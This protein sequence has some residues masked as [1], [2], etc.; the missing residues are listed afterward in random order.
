MP[1]SIE[2]QSSV[3]NGNFQS[4]PGDP[5]ANVD[6]L[7]NPLPG[8][9]LV[10][11]VNAT[12]NVTIVADSG[13]GS[14]NVCRFTSV[15]AALND[16]TYLEQLIPVFGTRDQETFHVPST[17]M[18]AGGTLALGLST[19][20]SGQYLLSDQV[21]TTGTAQE[22]LVAWNTFAHGITVPLVNAGGIPTNAGWLRLRLGVR[23]T[24]ASA[25][26]QT[27]DIAYV[28]VNRAT[29]GLYLVDTTNPAARLPGLLNQSGG[30]ARIAPNGQSAVYFEVFDGAGTAANAYARAL[31]ASKDASLGILGSG[32]LQLP[33]SAQPSAGVPAGTFG[34]IHY[35]GTHFYTITNAG[36]HTQI[37]STALPPNGAA[38]G[39]LS[40]TYPNPGYAASPT[41]T[42]TVTAPLIALTGGQIAFPAAQAAS[43]GVN[44]LDDYEEGT[45]TP[46][47]TFATPGNLSVAYSTQNG[48]YVKVG[49][50][51][52]VH[53]DIITTT[54]TFTTAS[55][56]FNI[57]G[58]PF[59]VN[60]RG[61]G[62][63]QFGGWTSGFTMLSPL[64][65][66][67][68]TIISL[69]GSQTATSAGALTTA[70]FTTAT[71]INMRFTA[72][73]QA[74]T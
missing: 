49:Q 66:N 57:T 10:N 33:T 27:Q 71:N 65:T 29:V 9:H 7:L 39:V 2:D 3:E 59:T 51:V 22:V 30:A 58:L 21:T 54:F 55:G 36:V 32:F 13:S 24:I 64:C 26:T 52:I 11:L 6:D 48:W 46:V 8:W 25:G 68:G 67:G 12:I 70:Q 56:N 20:L 23:C 18:I 4:E 50:L 47:A 53:C 17:Y 16:E 5:T 28:A 45:W 14:G 69:I 63:G 44:T 37:D 1:Q 73:Y 40:G 19:Y 43:A 35:D 31:L 62:S 15:G 74:A 72:V 42:G 34:G 61:Y 38:G 41:F 60:S